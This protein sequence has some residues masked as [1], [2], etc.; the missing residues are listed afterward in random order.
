MGEHKGAGQWHY[1]EIQSRL[2]TTGRAE[3]GVHTPMPHTC[4][5]LNSEARRS[6][7]AYLS[8]LS[9]CLSSPHV[10]GTLG[11]GARGSH[12][13]SGS[14]SVAPCGAQG[15]P[16]LLS[17]CAVHALSSRGDPDCLRL[18]ALFSAYPG[19]V[20]R[21]QLD[22]TERRAGTRLLGE[23]CFHALLRISSDPS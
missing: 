19:S 23:I 14:K 10:L 9:G 4:H 17:F 11:L 7:C 1:G 18:A 15:R 12:S 16:V 13:S 3:R 22:W 6:D 2:R 8:L 5:V 21:A 20:C